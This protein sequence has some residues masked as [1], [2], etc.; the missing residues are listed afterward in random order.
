MPSPLLH[1]DVL[2]LVKSNSGILSAYDAHTGNAHYGP[3]RLP[4]V[5]SVYASP[6]AANGR[7]YILGR[8]GNT[9]VVSAGTTFEVLASNVLDD[10][11]DAS[12]AVAGGEIYLRGQRYL[13]CIANDSPGG[14]AG[15]Q[16]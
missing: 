15:G 9:S 6:V 5:R 16:P 7:V 3:T 8:E 4:G 10:G 14:R 2:Y 11:F 1:D 12:P 13:Y